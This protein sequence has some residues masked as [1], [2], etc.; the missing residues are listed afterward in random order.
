MKR[1]KKDKKE[2]IG[3]KEDSWEEGRIIEVGY[4]VESKEEE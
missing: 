4:K 2:R 1:G 3:Q